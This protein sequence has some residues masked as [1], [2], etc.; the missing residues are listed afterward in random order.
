M[1]KRIILVA[2][3]GG[4]KD[5]FRD[6]LIREQGLKADVS[7]TTRPPRKGE[8]HGVTYHFTDDEEFN[9]LKESK[10]FYEN[11]E[12]NGWQYG[13]LL[14][15]WKKSDVFIMTP[16]GIKHLSED[17]R[18]ESFI[19]YFDI[20]VEDRIE[21][22]KLRSDADSVV[23]RVEAD[24]KDF[25]GFSNYDLRIT[26]PLFDCETLFQKIGDLEKVPSI[27]LD[28]D[29]VIFDYNQHFLDYLGFEDKTPAQS[30]HDP[31][32]VDNFHKIANDTNFWSTIPS[33]VSQEEVDLINK[34]V[35][36]FIT[37]RT[38][39]SEVSAA[40]L[41][42]IG[43]DVDSKTAITVGYEK[44]K[45]DCIKELG[46]EMFLDDAV[47]NYEEINSNTNCL[48]YI[49]TRSHN[50]SYFISPKFRFNNI[51]EFLNHCIT[52]YSIG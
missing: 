24:K 46:V 50:E 6:Y 11:V 13:T 19:V 5:F 3:A 10:K 18:M 14:N 22:L 12:F 45:I 35:R 37:A 38:V 1:N 28:L 34:Y 51:H 23:R 27:H 49:K 9:K 29:G 32:F 31:R 20:P 52:K 17:D 25:E 39:P 33:I 21:R 36:G 26:D 4:G 15:S 43:I 7:L 40:A 41:K 42:S 2:P 48:C 30:W 47:H 16:S 8:V 44:T